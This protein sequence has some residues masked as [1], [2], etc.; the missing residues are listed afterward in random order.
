MQIVV[1][2]KCGRQVNRANYPTNDPESYYR[3]SIFI[4][5]LDNILHDYESRFS[6]DTLALYNFTILFPDSST[7]HNNDLLNETIAKLAE[8]YYIFFDNSIEM[9]K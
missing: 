5:L 1:P 8:K 4:P 9:L 2:R 3:Q 7:W 6:E